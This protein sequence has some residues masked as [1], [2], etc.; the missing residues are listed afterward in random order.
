MYVHATACLE[1][2][3]ACCQCRRDL[4]ARGSM[5]I[6]QPI[7]M[8]SSGIA[9]CRSAGIPMGA[10][11]SS[12]AHGAATRIWPDGTS[13]FTSKCWAPIQR[14]G[15]QRRMCM[16]GLLWLWLW[17]WLCLTGI[18][19]T[20]FHI[21]C[22]GTLWRWTGD[23]SRMTHQPLP[24]MSGVEGQS[25]TADTAQLWHC[26]RRQLLCQSVCDW[27]HSPGVLGHDVVISRSGVSAALL[28]SI[29]V[30]RL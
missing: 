7:M 28:T 19:R 13:P 4:T 27:P 2:Q 17:L 23:V 26:G 24:G 15:A 8:S 10:A 18:S 16:G 14:Q 20:E 6:Q 30:I 29:L 25:D 1:L 9:V 22:H 21:L 5:Q 3:A 11:A 12:A